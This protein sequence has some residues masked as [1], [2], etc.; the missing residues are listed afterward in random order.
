MHSKEAVIERTRW[1]QGEEKLLYW[2]YSYGTVIGS[3]FATLQPHRVGRVVIDGVCD[4]DDYYH[5]GWLANLQDTDLVMEHFYEY[6]SIA[7]PSRCA[8]A[9]KNSSTADI[10]AQIEALVANIKEDPIPVPGNSTRGPEIITYSDMM[11][12]IRMAL[13][14]PLKAFPQMADLLADLAYG[15]GTA[16]AA[17]KQDAHK[18]SCPLQCKNPSSDTEP[19]LPPTSW[20]TTSGIMCSDGIDV[21]NSTKDDFRGVLAE[22]YGQSKWMGEVWSTIVVPCFHWK[23][24]AAWTL[25]A[26]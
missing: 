13:Y 8:M 21:S 19:C 15:N 3:T 18:P 16:F 4:T 2:G 1:R 26:G 24:K 7:G 12:M 6:C 5:T 14:K 9:R 11:Q 17:F 23:G 25:T 20:E 10:K 22:L